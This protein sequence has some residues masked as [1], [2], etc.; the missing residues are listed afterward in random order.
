MNDFYIS[1][2]HPCIPHFP[3]RYRIC[4]SECRCDDPSLLVNSITEF[5]I[6][7]Q[8]TLGC[9]AASPHLQQRVPNYSRVEINMRINV[10]FMDSISHIVVLEVQGII[11]KVSG[12]SI[13]EMSA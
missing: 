5:E 2:S 13:R 10:D 1:A 11:Q 6:E 9:I 7:K 12:D 4:R 3:D 8:L